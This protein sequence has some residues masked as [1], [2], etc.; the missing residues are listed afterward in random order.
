[1]V[2]AMRQ[3]SIPSGVGMDKVKMEMTLASR[4]NNNIE[5]L[6]FQ[7]PDSTHFILTATQLTLLPRLKQ[8]DEVLQSTDP[9]SDGTIKERIKYIVSHISNM[10]A[11]PQIYVALG[12]MGLFGA[13]AVRALKSVLLGLLN[14]AVF[15]GYPAIKS[16]QSIQARTETFGSKSFEYLRDHF[17]RPESRRTSQESDQQDDDIQWKSYWIMYALIHIVEKRFNI[18][19][20]LLPLKKTLKSVLLIWL[21]HPKFRGAES[22]YK[23]RLLPF[24]VEKKRDFDLF[25]KS[26]SLLSEIRRRS[27]Q[28]YL[29][30]T[31]NESPVMN[32]EVD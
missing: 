25:V 6:Y 2:A 4:I 24:Y 17:P 9:K 5:L 8:I 13:T 7:L 12:L 32:P 11:I 3:T 16:I 22:V 30:E 28:N 20:S 10:T 31:N 23:S 26:T 29:Y 21:M 18:A 14:D 15:I 1:M 19:I 27:S